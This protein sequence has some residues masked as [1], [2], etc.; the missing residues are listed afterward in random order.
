MFHLSS[1]KKYREAQFGISNNTNIIIRCNKSWWYP[2]KKSKFSWFT[3][4]VNKHRVRNQWTEYSRGPLLRALR[5]RCTG[6]NHTNRSRLVEEVKKYDLQNRFRY[7]ERSYQNTPLSN[8]CNKQWWSS[9]HNLTLIWSHLNRCLGKCCRKVPLGP[10]CTWQN[11]H[12][13]V[14]GVCTSIS[15]VNW[16]KTANFWTP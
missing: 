6:R 2:L 3:G 7:H 4:D 11:I 5:Y 10:L 12:R 1:E 16:G 13:L 14:E 9:R 15:L 8:N